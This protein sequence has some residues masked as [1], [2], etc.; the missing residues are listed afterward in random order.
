MATNPFAGYEGYEETTYKRPDSG[1]PSTIGQTYRA[2]RDLQDADNSDYQNRLYDEAFASTLEAVNAVRRQ[3]G[4]P[5]FLPPSWGKIS[6]NQPM[7]K[8]MP[9]NVYAATGLLDDASREQ[10]ADALVAEVVRIRQSR[11]GFLSDLPGSREQILAPYI[12]R[13]QAKRARARG[14]L[15]RSEGVGGTA[16][17]IAGG[18]T[19]AMEDP[20]NI[21]TMPIGGGGRTVLGIAAREALV[22]GLVEVL[23]IPT[24]AENRE[25]LGED[26]TAGEAAQNVLYAAGGS[27]VLAG[28][29]ASAGKYGGRAWEKLTPIEKK[30]ARAL[31]AAEITSPT[32]LERQVIGEILGGLD[33]G[34]LVSLAREQDLLGDPNVAAAAA[35]IGRQ[36]EIDAN[37]PYIAGSGDAYA[38]IGRAHV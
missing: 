8:A 13:D 28:L 24:V 34:E 21:I 12:A 33:D 25:L 2:A 18:V 11:P 16:A 9:V 6:R 26:L 31:E 1:P 14:V 35:A 19:K 22:G 36:S 3:Q 20:W 23:Q 27:A 17:A 32:Q 38:E 7:A 30:L 29:I 15:E 10:V 37:N 5:L 4:L